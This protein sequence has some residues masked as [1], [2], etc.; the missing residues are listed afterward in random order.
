MASLPKILDLI[1]ALKLFPLR[2]WNWPLV[3]P[4]I[5]NLHRQFQYQCALNHLL[6]AMS[7]PEPAAPNLPS[8]LDPQKIYKV[9]II[10]LSTA[11]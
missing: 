1:Y 10:Q 8:M 4:A 11:I 6:I 2:V 3:N 5:M 9:S 7:P